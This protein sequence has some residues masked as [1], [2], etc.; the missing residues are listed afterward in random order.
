LILIAS[1]LLTA[2]AGFVA[3][4]FPKLLLRVG[5]GDESPADSA[6][7]FVR[8]WGV[9]IIAVGALIVS[10]AYVPAIRVAVLVAAAVEK[11]AMGLLVFFGPLKRTTGLT[12]ISLMDGF[13]AVVYVAYLASL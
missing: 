4:F 9:L 13:F 11:F 6:V 8:H 5:F 1:G 2:G 7:F 10:C 3:L 12:A